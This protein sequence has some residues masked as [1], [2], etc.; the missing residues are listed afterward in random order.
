MTAK[1]RETGGKGGR[2]Q[3]RTGRRGRTAA[4]PGNEATGPGNEAPATGF[5]AWT[6]LLLYGVVTLLLF[7]EFVFSDL[8]LLGQDT[9]ALGY[10]ARAFF[11]DAL[12]TTGFPLWNPFILGGTPF[13]DALAGGDSLYP[14]SL[15]LLVLLETYRALGWKLVLHVF[16]AGCFMFGWLRAVGASRGA[17]M[18][19]GLAYLLA[20]YMVT[21]VYPGHDGKLFVTALSPLVFWLAEWSLVRRGLVPLAVLGASVALVIL[22]TH[23]QMAYFL[24]GAVGVYVIVRTVQ[25]GRSGSGWAGPARRFGLFLAFSLVGAGAAGVQLIPAV[26]YVTEHSRRAHTSVDAAAQEGRAWASSW[27]LHPEEVV[28]LAVPEFVG[29][30]AGGAEWATDTYWGRNIFKHNHEY[31]GLVVLLLAALSFI[32]GARPWLRWFMVGLG[33]TTLLFALGPHTPVWRIFYEVV[34]G[35]ALFRAPSMAIFL[36]GF[37]ATTLAALGIDRGLELVREGEARRVLKVLGGAAGLLALGWVLAATGIFTEVWT[38]LVYRD[39][40][41]GARRSLESAMPFISRGFLLAA[42]LAL[43]VTGAWWALGEGYLKPPVLIGLLAALVAVDQVRVND[44]FIQHLDYHRYAA[45]DG[46]QR[47]LMERAREEEPF[48]VFSLIQQAQDVTPALHGL[49]LAAGHHP[50]D[51]GR[52]RELIGMVGSGMPEHLARFN[53]NLLDIL[54]VRYIVWP[55]FQFGP[56]EGAEAVSRVTFADGQVYASVF[57]YPALPRARLV[58]RAL[59]VPEDVALETILDPEAYNPRLEAVLTEEPPI[60]LEGLLDGGE[61]RWIERTPNRLVL[62]VET[63]AP[64]LLVLSENWFPDWRA[65]VGG[66]E[67]PVLRADHTLRAVPVPSGRHRVEMWF[68]PGRIRNSLFL[69]LACVLLLVGAGSAGWVRERRGRGSH[70]PAGTAPGAGG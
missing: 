59:V 12:A 13:I 57:R 1:R 7:R 69:S 66:E 50:N 70:E 42:L 2:R 33:G 67:A 47:F 30:D 53:P 55:D 10:V 48:R 34:P 62:E 52:Y 44:A 32:G 23:F 63:P 11:A 61:A 58:G 68:D 27:S 49:E 5:P 8:M 45:P 36:T 26:S 38:T 16:L 19:G 24:F 22:T 3:A 56:L 9:L 6:V 4:G 31:L 37:A 18:V 54:N 17:S 25:Q 65:T 15:L 46:N 20:P 64:A 51:L 43:G 35:I 60:R 21:L 41:E 14:P 39:I 28:S 29:N 40:E